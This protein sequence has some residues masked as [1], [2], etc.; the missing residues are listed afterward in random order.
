MSFFFSFPSS[1]K[2]LLVE[3]HRLKSCWEYSFL[4]FY[5][6]HC[7]IE[8]R[9]WGWWSGALPEQQ[10]PWWMKSVLLLDWHLYF[11]VGKTKHSHVGTR[12]NLMSE[13]LQNCPEPWLPGLLEIWA[14]PNHAGEVTGSLWVSITPVHKIWLDIFSL[15]LLY[16]DLWT[17]LN[18][19][20]LE[21]PK[22]LTNSN[23][24]LVFK[25]WYF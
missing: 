17:T 23:S 2:Y 3:F 20:C 6:R 18:C 12:L 24:H 15:D 14:W 1:F 22:T 19:I 4:Q 13:Y 9:H 5:Q 21:L 8:L 11:R 25:S 16:C 7:V 10:N